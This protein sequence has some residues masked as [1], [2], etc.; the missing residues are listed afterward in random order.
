MN[1]DK[2]FFQIPSLDGTWNEKKIGE[3]DFKREY[4]YKKKIYIRMNDLQN[5]INKVKEGLKI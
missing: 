1:K 5:E 3:N 4:I 2:E